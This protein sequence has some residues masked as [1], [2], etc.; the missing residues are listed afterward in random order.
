MLSKINPKQILP[1][2]KLRTLQKS[3]RGYFLKLIDA[4]YFLNLVDKQRELKYTMNPV[5]NKG[6]EVL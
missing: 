3:L 6:I 2:D 5:V 1:F 4:I